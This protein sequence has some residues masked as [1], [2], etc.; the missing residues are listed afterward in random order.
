[1]GAHL[2]GPLDQALV[3]EQGQGVADRIAGDVEFG[4]QLRF[5]GQ[6]AIEGAGMDLLAQ[7]VGDLTGA[8]RT[9]RWL[10]RHLVSFRRLTCDK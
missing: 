7:Y 3:L 4:R 9:A 5:A 1:M 2:G 10:R 6:R 8:V